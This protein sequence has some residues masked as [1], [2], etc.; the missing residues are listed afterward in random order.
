MSNLIYAFAPEPGQVV[1][2]RGRWAVANVQPQGLPRSPADGPPRTHTS[3]TS[4]ARRT[5]GSSSRRVGAGVGRTSTCSGLPDVIYADAFDEPATL[6]G[7]IDAMR[8]VRSECRPQSLPGAAWSGVNVEA[9]QLEPCAAHLPHRAN[10]L[11]ADDVG[12]GKTIE[13]GLVIQ[14]LF[15]V[16]APHRRHRLPAQPRAEVAGRDAREVRS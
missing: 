11:L 14:E 2:V 5:T 6:A 1:E 3:S 10:L 12:L 4:V 15:C 7:F 8:W 13:A 9:Y 16:T